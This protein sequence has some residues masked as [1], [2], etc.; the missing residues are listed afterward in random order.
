[1]RQDSALTPLEAGVANPTEK[2]FQRCPKH[3]AGANR[4]VRVLE[5]AAAQFAMTGLNGTTAAALAEA[6]GI[7]EPVLYDHFDS[8][9]CLFRA[10]VEANIENRLAMLSARLASIPPESLIQC[11]ESLAEATVAVCVSGPGNAVLTNW[12]LLEA[13]DYAVDLYRDEIGSVGILWGQELAKRFPESRS[14]AALSIHL[15]AFAVNV[16]LAYGFWLAT[17]RHTPESSA[18]L[19]R[20]FAA[21]IA[22]AASAILSGQ[23]KE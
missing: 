21:G 17:L 6:A 1:M 14:L 15:G 20:Q 4:R 2:G 7:S 18:P 8:K 9:E 10:A 22:K 16:C 3:L 23:S 12:A 5:V 13:P 19:R 11:F